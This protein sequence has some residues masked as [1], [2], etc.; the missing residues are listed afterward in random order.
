MTKTTVKDIIN[1]VALFRTNTA[2]VVKDKKTLETL[3]TAN[4]LD[5]IVKFIDKTENSVVVYVK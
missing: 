5:K 2:V 1:K 4:A 3:E